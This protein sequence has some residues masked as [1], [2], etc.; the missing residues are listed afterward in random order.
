VESLKVKA[1]SSSPSTI[2]KKKDRIQFKVLWEEA[3]TVN[4][5]TRK[6]VYSQ[7]LKFP[8]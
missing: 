1:L 6:D 7:W 3:T 4:A 5:Y 8:P 2:K